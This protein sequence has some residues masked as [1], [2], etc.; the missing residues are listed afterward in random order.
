MNVKP[1]DIAVI[2]QS[3]REDPHHFE[4]GEVVRVGD[5]YNYPYSFK[6]K[7]MCR[8]SVGLWWVLPK[9]MRV[10]K[11]ED[12]INAALVAYKLRKRG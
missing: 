2:E 11:D 1:G 12:E 8:K 7:S 5:N 6:C 3:I 10:L 4:I 9:E